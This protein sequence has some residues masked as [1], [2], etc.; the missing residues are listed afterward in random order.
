MKISRLCSSQV[1]RVKLGEDVTKQTLVLEKPFLPS[2]VTGFS[3]LVAATKF[4]E[5]ICNKMF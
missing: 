2:Q 4:S 1:R 3:G 5:K